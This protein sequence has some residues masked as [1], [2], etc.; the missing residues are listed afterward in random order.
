MPIPGL[1]AA[2]NISANQFEAVKLSGSNPFEVTAIA[3]T[4]DNAIG[5]LQDDPDAAGEA[6]EVA[7]PGEVAKARY[8]GNVTAGNLL[9]FDADGELIA[10][11]PAAG[12]G[13]NHRIIAQALEDGANQEVHYVLVL[14]V[15]WVETA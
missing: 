1:V 3:A 6:A 5:I 7:G 9:G 4:T 14:G 12:G 2:G 13:N 11:T 15:S 8:G 10:R